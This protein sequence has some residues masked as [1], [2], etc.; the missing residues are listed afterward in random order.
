MMSSPANKHVLIVG[1]GFAGLGCAT[2]LL[3]SG[4]VKVTLLDRHNYHQ[5]QP[6]FYALFAS[7]CR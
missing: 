6:L 3:R 5:F 7:Y 4:N 1:G 2:T